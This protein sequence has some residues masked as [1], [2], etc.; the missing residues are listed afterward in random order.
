M[1]IPLPI[2]KGAWP[3]AIAGAVILALV[4]LHVWSLMR[5]PRPF[6]D[7][8]WFANRAWSL[9]RHGDTIGSLD[10][11]VVDRFPGARLF[12]PLLPV[13]VQAAALS[14]VHEPSLLA[15]RVVSLVAGAGLTFAIWS[16]A[17]SA[18]DRAAALGSIVILALSEPFFYSS[19]LARY[20]V[21]AAALAFGGIA[22]YLRSGRNRVLTAGLGGL[23]AGVAMEFHPFAVVIA[24][25]LPVLAIEEFGWRVHHHPVSRTLALGLLAGSAVYPGIH[26]FPNPRTY[27]AISRLLYGPTHVPF[28]NP[29]GTLITDSLGLTFAMFKFAFPVLV[30]AVISM[31][32]SPERRDRRV[33]LLAISVF[34]AFTVI[35]RNKLLYYAILFSPALVLCL[36][37]ALRQ[38]I[39]KWRSYGPVALV[40]VSTALALVSYQTC[41]V[42]IGILTYDSRTAFQDVQRRI[43]TTIRPGESIMGPQTYWFGLSDHRYYSWEQLIYLQRLHPGISAVQALEMMQPDVFIRD[44]DVDQFVRDQPGDTL[45]ERLLRL[46]KAEMETWLAQ[47]S[48]LVADFDAEIY[49]RV[50]VYRLR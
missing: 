22:L 50:R 37:I 3:E 2:R 13:I 35:V 29:I 38:A 44:R 49:G 42:G 16:I 10:V 19:H 39:G 48:T 25:A 21:I 1:R 18:Y 5:F 26:V 7:E 31:A 43:A 27:L 9:L 15:L 6:V 23:F 20:D 8:A 45:Y 17:R 30:W 46:P 36:A 32:V 11:G 47:H 33:A 12:F 34:G 40:T 14:F 28:A 41:L 4:F 24:V